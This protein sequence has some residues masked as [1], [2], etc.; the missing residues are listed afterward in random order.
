MTV[1]EFLGRL[2]RVKRNGTGWRARCPG[3]DD[4]NP[5]M[6]VSEGDDGR[7]LVKCWA[8]CTAEAIVAALGLEIRDLYPRGGGGASYPRRTPATVQHPVGCTLEQYAEAKRL[9][10]DFLRGLGLSEIV[11]MKSPAVRIPYLGADG[12]ELCV[13]FRVAVAGEVTVRAKAG[14]KLCLY[15]LN[16][17][18]QA[19]EAGYVV[20]EEGES[21][22]QTSWLHGFPALGLPGASSWNEQRDAEH[23]DGIGTVYVLIEPDRGGEAVL[24][25]LQASSVRDRVRLVRLDGAKDVSELYLADPDRFVERFEAALQAAIP[26]AEHE[27]VAAEIRTRRAWELAGPLARER[28][29]LDV[30]ERDLERMGVAG[31][32]R[33]AKLIYLSLTSRFL[34][35]PVSNAVKGPSGGGKSYLVERVCEFFPPDAYYPLTAMSERALAYGTEPLRHRFLVLYEAAGLESDFASYLVR[36]LLS[37]GKVRYETVEKGPN[38]LEP[39]LIERE[40]P[41]GLI[42]TTTAVAL[43]PE[44]ETRLLSM[45]VTDT[46]EQT[47]SVLLSLAD[48]HPEPDRAAWR[49]LQTWLAGVEHRVVIPYA[50]PLAELVPPVAVRLRRDFGAILALIRAHAVLHQVHRDRDGQGRVVATIDDYQVVRELVADL[51]SEGAEATVPTT[52]RE[53]VEA[54]ASIAAGEGVSLTKLAAELG[55]DKSAAARR[56]QAARRRGHLTNE[57]TKRGTP[58]RLKLADPLPD[59]VEILPSPDRLAECCSVAT[60]LGGI[61]IPPSPQ[62]SASNGWAALDAEEMARLEALGEE[63]GL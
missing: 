31:E 3:H 49:D 52:V 56:W 41:T 35:R 61:G 51:I 5:S 44:N 21:C 62:V 11:Y 27:R 46:P 28:R 39:R 9:P 53:T 47:R 8:G 40:G 10:A 42:V 12:T 6:S 26:W 36:S 19:R 1:E 60:V 30:F 25:W 15:G 59:D 24:R 32:A 16:R 57:E 7:V 17:L 50:R 29:I 2:E 23:L 34:P 58:A 22:A 63:M 55:I 4:T 14:S 45:Q 54:V 48:E 43:H 20:I 13:R 38:G 33:V 37:E 18:E